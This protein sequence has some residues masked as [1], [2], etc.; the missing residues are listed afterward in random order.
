M[1]R[2]EHN[3]DLTNYLIILGL[4][5]WKQNAGKGY[6]ICCIYIFRK[7]QRKVKLFLRRA[8][9]RIYYYKS[10]QVDSYGF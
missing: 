2:P 1:F 3:F 6:R 9:L 5:C 7:E 10:Q 4:S 8:V